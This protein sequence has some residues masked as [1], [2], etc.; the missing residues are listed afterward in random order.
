[1]V[2]RRVSFSAV[3]VRDASKT[4]LALVGFF[5]SLRYGLDVSV[6]RRFCIVFLLQSWFAPKFS[7][8]GTASLLRSLH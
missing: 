2:G 5:V 1:V 6:K 3:L 7:P 4:G 8:A